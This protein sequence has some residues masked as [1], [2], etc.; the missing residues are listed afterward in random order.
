M[1][2]VIRI[3]IDTTRAVAA[4]LDLLAEQAAE[5]ETRRP[6]NPAATAI[7]R[8]LAPFRLVEYAYVDEGVGAI[9]G[10]YVGFPDGSLYAA[11]DEIPD[12]AVC[13][14]VQG[15]EERVVDLPPLYIYVVL[16]QPVGREAIDAFLTELSSHVGHALVGVVPGADGRLKARVFDAEGTKGVAREADRHLSKQVLVE[17]FAQRSQCSDGRAFAALSYAFARQ[18]LEFATVAE[19]DDFVAWS[20]VLCDWIFAHGDDAAQL[21]FAEAHRPAEPAPI[22]DDGRATIR[23]AS[24]SAYADGSAWA[25]LAPDAPPE[26][27]GPVRDY[28][29]YVRRTIDAVRAGSAD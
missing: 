10:A 9:L 28:W 27:L 11:G 1:D 29:N 8:E 19:R 14:L 7:W 26:A 3:R 17:R 16:A 21:G 22:P 4:F 6:A 23:L 2:D 5:G 15:N 25:C 13:D 20:R 12:S 18:S 24:P